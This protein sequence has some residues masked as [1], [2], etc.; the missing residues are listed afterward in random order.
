MFTR[1]GCHFVPEIT[2]ESHGGYHGRIKKCW[3]L[4]WS[5]STGED[6]DDRQNRIGTIKVKKAFHYPGN[7]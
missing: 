5:I 4:R 3:S 2:P 6:E 7:C 1:P